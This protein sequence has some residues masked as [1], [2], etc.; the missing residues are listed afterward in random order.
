VNEKV[1]GPLVD[2]MKRE[3]A[4][5]YGENPIENPDFP[6]I[7]SEKAFDRLSELI[8]GDKVLSGGRRDRLK[9]SIE[10]TLIDA[11][12]SDRCMAE[13]IFGPILPVITFR[14]LK[15][16]IDYINSGEK[17]LAVYYFSNDRKKQK[18]MIC[19]T[20]SGACLI[21]EVILHI[22]NSNLPFGGVGDSGMGR[23]HGKESFRA[24]SNMKAVMKSSTIIDV[25]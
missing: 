20:S 22:A 1:K 5:M 25:P 17:P 13:E 12:L 14:N 6:K 18:R 24:F 4:K 3:I 7:V 21:N 8:G 15:E 23:Y 2:Q 11:S 16:T 10:P 19:E 9:L